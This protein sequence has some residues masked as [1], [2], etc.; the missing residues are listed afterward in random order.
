V[1]QFEV[2]FVTQTDILHSLADK[3]VY[4]TSKIFF[5]L[6]EKKHKIR[7]DLCWSLPNIFKHF[8]F[9]Y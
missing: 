1:Q 3:K 7:K 8:I 9:Y 2:G 4:F 6:I 5:F